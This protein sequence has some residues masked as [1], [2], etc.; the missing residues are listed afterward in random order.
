MSFLLRGA[1]V[2]YGLDLIG[3]IP[4]VVLFQF[5]PD[6]V[7]RAQVVPDRSSQREQ[8]QASAQ[9]T[10]ETIRF[11]AVF[12]AADLTDENWPLARAFGI[13][14]QLA[15]LEKMVHPFDRVQTLFGQALDAIGDAI[16]LGGDDESEDAQPIPRREYP[17]ILM[18]WGPFRILPVTVTGMEI[19]E[20]E[21]D[22]LLNPTKADV[23]ISL[24]VRQPDPCSNDWLAFGAMEIHE[25]RQ[26]V[27]GDRESRNQRKQVVEI[28]DI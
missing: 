4:N 23:T 13:N 21:F 16:G 20:K 22:A 11:K 15:A 1:L 8:N 17:R 7:T 5:N 10:Y 27:A 24:R 14:P 28:F 26:G 12:D 9:V 3:P 6:E 25:G 2:E 19:V 18:V